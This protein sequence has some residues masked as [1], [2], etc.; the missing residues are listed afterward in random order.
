MVDIAEN[1]HVYG[2]VIV[3]I[4]DKNI[5]HFRQIQSDSDGTFHDLGYKYTKDRVKEE[6]DVDVVLGDLHA[7]DHD[8]TV[9]QATKNMLIELKTRN[10]FV[11]DA[12]SG[13]SISHYD[14]NSIHRKSKK[15]QENRNNFIEEVKTNCNIFSDLLRNISGSIYRVK[16]N[17]DEWY[18]RYLE[19]GSYVNDVVNHYESLRY[20][21]KYLEGK[22]PLVEAYK[23]YMNTDDL[24]RMNFLQRK[25]S[26]K[27][28]NVELAQ[29]GDLS[30]NGS[31]GSLAGAEKSYGNCVI[32]HSHSAAIF[33]GVFRVG[34]LTK[35]DLGYN[36]GPSTW[37]HTNCIVYS[38]GQRQLIN[39][40]NG[41]YR[42][43]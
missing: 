5:F 43:D 40:I 34:T 17:H 39:I 32:G 12:F 26:Y 36:V 13:Y 4:E 7:G 6:V 31:R 35:L 42:N 21:M 9:Y 38:N 10:I 25:S 3:E 14:E 24:K 37:T 11:H 19:R 33:R 1:D 28:A 8:E 2:A 15:Y 27:I 23:N 30:I 41:K 22:E 29:H 20:A 16:G 18:E